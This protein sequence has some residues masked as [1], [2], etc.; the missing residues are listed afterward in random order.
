MI[1]KNVCWYVCP[2]Y[3]AIGIFSL[4]F[5]IDKFHACLIDT[6]CVYGSSSSSQ[7]PKISA[8]F[9]DN[10]RDTVPKMYIVEFTLTHVA[11]N[12]P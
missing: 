8:Y 2:A 10:L 1:K 7:V 3:I 4:K 6:W 12:G 11:T 5:I 9:E